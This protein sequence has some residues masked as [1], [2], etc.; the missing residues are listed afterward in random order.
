MAIPEGEEAGLPKALAALH[1]L[2][3]APNDRQL[4]SYASL[5]YHKL[6]RATANTVRHGRGRPRWETVEAFVAACLKFAE[7]RK[8]PVK[9]P[10][11]YSDMS[12]WRV[13]YDYFTAVTSAAHRGKTPDRVALSAQLPRSLDTPA[14]LLDPQSGVVEFIGRVD[15]LADLLA[16][17]EDDSAGRLRLITGCGGIGKTRLALQ[18][19]ARLRELGWR[20][21]WVGDRQEAHILANVRAVSPG[22]LFL[23][24]DYAE[25]RIRLEELL[26][27]V[28]A[29]NGK[30]RLLLLARSAGQWWEQLAAGEV[31]IWDLLVQGGLDIAANREPGRLRGVLIP[32]GEVLDKEISDEEQVLRAVPVFAAA[33]GVSPPDHVSVITRPGRARVLELHA[34]ALVAVLEWVTAPKLKPRVELGGVLNELLRHE[35]RFWLGSALAQGLVYGLTGMTPAMLRQVVAAGCLLGA[36]DQNEAVAL[37]GRVPGV[38]KSVK[39]AEWLR[40]LYPPVQDS[41]EWLGMVQPDRLAERLVI[42]QLSSSEELTQACLRELGERE[43]R[44]AL[45]LLAR[46]ATEDDIAERLLRRLVPLV[47]QVIADIDAPLETLVSIAN[48]IPYPSMALGQAHAAITHRIL[49][50]PAAHSHPSEYARW[51]T[52]RGLTLTQLSRPWDALLVTEQAAGLYRELTTV[53]PGRYHPELAGSLANLGIGLSE[54]GSP[55]EALTVTEEA[56]TLY[57]NLAEAHPDRYQP[58]LAATLTNLGTRFS[59]V[60]RHAD[61]LL[62]TQEAASF[63]HNLAEAHPDRYQSELAATLTNLGTRF[64]EVRRHADALL[65]TQEAARL[66]RDLAFANPDQYRPDHAATLANLGA[67]YSE[68]GRHAEALGATQEAASLLQ[69]AA[70]ASPDRYRPNVAGFLANLAGQLL[71]LGRPAEALPAGQEALRIYREL[72]AV[73]P[74]W[75]RPN[76]AAVLAKLGDVFS[77]LR[78]PAEAVTATQ[79][80]VDS[81]RELTAGDPERYKPNLAAY[82]MVLGARLSE[83]DCPAEALSAEREAISLYREL[84]ADN[85]DWYR[86]NLA[87][88][89]IIL[90]AQ[91]SQLHRPADALRPELEA[92]SLYRELAADDPE[93]YRPDLAASLTSLGFRLS[94][95]GRGGDALEATREAVM[96][97]LEQEA[98]KPQPRSSLTTSVIV[99][100]SGNE[101]PD[102]PA[103]QNAIGLYRTLPGAL[104]F[105][106]ELVAADRWYRPDLALSL[107]NLVTH[108]AESGDQAEALSAVKESVSLYRELAAGDPNWYRPNLALA[109]MVLGA[110]HSQLGHLT[111]ALS[112][113]Q[114][115]IILYRE[116]AADRPD[117]YRP[118]L[119]AA[120]NSLGFR[121]SDLGFASEALVVTREATRLYHEQAASSRRQDP[122]RAISYPDPGSEIPDLADPA[123]ALTAAQETVKLY[124]TL[125][126]INPCQYKPSLA[127]SLIRLGTQLLEAD[128]INTAL[129]AQQEAVSI[130]Q[131][132]E[133]INRDQYHS[134]LINALTRLAET[135]TKLKNTSGISESYVTAA[136]AKATAARAKTSI[137]WPPWEPAQL[138]YSDMSW[139]QTLLRGR[140][141]E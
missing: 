93:Q 45:L 81:Y 16:W 85:P 32:L 58:E 128:R 4:E 105:Y 8:P 123:G 30:I 14:R 97:Y 51:L 116:L 70:A 112:A 6:P 7:T 96:I 49:D 72:S 135:V 24:V 68:V 131:E 109:L 73:N 83:S 20:C 71:A 120:L 40:E 107:I 137:Q 38:P 33:L 61:A 62:V 13:R 94:E 117:R 129:S 80:A 1:A 91:L 63:F 52:I 56:L 79:E 113:E 90:G 78:C 50:T 100:E 2:V 99:S 69:D 55:A 114:E 124:R 60:G 37:L 22:P 35:E 138:P 130:Y 126:A 136:R 64:S 125:T 29:D 77:A 134:G 44:R 59:E 11:E 110:L 111:E 26:R 19:T 65:V 88:A 98:V 21:E 5:A 67:R 118:I 57:R 104:S 95:L 18:L 139:S 9:V 42:S 122:V 106:R 36:A 108:L 74:D 84:A 119:A 47:G 76:L 39:L 41:N 43:A 115:A 140:H 86:P 15:E 3:G 133:A 132:L 17:C 75:Y 10:P 48:A 12:L 27:A 66:Y 103:A 89:L 92:I 87:L 54:I 102:N 31:A 101:N 23:V 34:A 25:T 121:L 141:S 53:N 28:A 127:D 46:A 82:L